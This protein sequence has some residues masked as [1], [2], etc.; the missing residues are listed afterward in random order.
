MPFFPQDPGRPWSEIQSPACLLVN[1][2]KSE[3]RLPKVVPQILA[4]DVVEILRLGHNQ[5][6][7]PFCSIAGHTRTCRCGGSTGTI[8]NR[9]TL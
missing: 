6:S 5:Q 8:L 7:R 4:L 2:G 9:P 1:C 3:L